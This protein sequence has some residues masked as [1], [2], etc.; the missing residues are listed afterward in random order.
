VADRVALVKQMPTLHDLSTTLAVVGL[1]RS[2]WYYQT[3]QAVTY[4]A[5]YA[6]LR[7]PLEQIARR[8][9]EYGYRR[10]AKELR[11]GH[12]LHVN[13][14]VVQKLHQLWDLPLRRQ[15][16]VPRPSAVRQLLTEL[17]DKINLVAGLQEIAPL[18]VFYTDFTEL[19]YARGKAYLIPLVDHTSKLVAGWAVGPQAN[20]ELALTAFT[21]AQRWLH[22]HGHPLAGVI[23]HHDR[24]PVF[25]GNEWLARLLGEGVRISF[26]L[27]G[28]KDNPEMESFNSR[29][30]S[31]NRSLL[32]EAESLAELV[33]VV[34]RRLWYYNHRRRHSSLGY[35]SPLE[36]LASCEAPR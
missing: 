32:V 22:E 7:K 4:E 11:A 9:P 12:G 3:R 18:Q 21:R 33:A 28:A 19:V 31:E 20:T 1:A 34:R 23:V 17:G 10:V 8:H 35:V 14:K 6:A 27:R 36:F 5:K 16:A 2:T 13:H 29:F 25:T 30:K 26:A 24:D 15:I